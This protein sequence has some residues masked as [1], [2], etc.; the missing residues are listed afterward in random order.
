VIRSAPA[1][2]GAS[3]ALAA[4]LCAVGFH[5]L[6]GCAGA[7]ASGGAGAG[8]PAGEGPLV[9]SRADLWI[10]IRD[11]RHVVTVAASDRVVYFGSSAGLERWDTLRE[12]WLAPLTSADDLPDDRITALA[13]DRFGTD[14]WIGTRRG[15]VRIAFDDVVEPV[16]G[17]PPAPVEALLLDPRD[18][19]VHALVGS[20]WWRGRGASFE[21]EAGPP[22]GPLE[23]AMR[24]QD[25]DPAEVPWLD[26]LYV[27]SPLSFDL[28]RLT[29]V[30]RDASGD[31]YAGTW[32]DN[33]RRWRSV[34]AEWEPLYFGLAGGGGGPVVEAAD[35]LWFLPGGDSERGAALAHASRGL[36]AWSYVAPRLQPALPSAIWRAGIA[37]GDTLFLAGDLGLA[38]GVGPH[39][40]SA[41]AEDVGRA[42]AL[43]ADGP[44][45]WIGTE[46][47]LVAWDR[48]AGSPPAPA[49]GP[50]RVT[51]LAVA[52]DAL[53]VGSEVGLWAA[54]RT[55]PFGSVADAAA[56]AE[57]L[58]PV[59][60]RGRSVRALALL[61]ALLLVASDRGL[62]VFDRAS[63][64]WRVFAAGEGTIEG[65][66]L[67]VASDG[68]NAWVGTER[69][70]ARWRPETGEWRSY[71]ESDGLAGAPVLHILA[72][73]DAV[74]ASTPAG[75]TR[76]AWPESEP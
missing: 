37:L 27:R 42:S 31:W 62:E 32:G 50:R 4:V 59:E 44:I 71:R 69:G 56:L 15:L 16:W 40:E 30:D 53:F 3:V 52:P 57:A 68:A 45:L 23:R 25:F 38:W 8:R 26:P 76:F 6:L 54:P 75:V 20:G 21:R 65:S 29:E 66:A 11:F 17:P 60:P 61:G 18:G 2:L 35:G 12:E 36:E 46:R 73:R 22:P 9:R 14:A 5:G 51:A 43:A 72:Q 74:W 49:F 19:T 70:L 13:V 34:Q 7:A 28:V 67:A 63:G 41:G 48:V 47:G 58:V 33:A 10:T 55:G 1:Q 39:W 64:E 24:A